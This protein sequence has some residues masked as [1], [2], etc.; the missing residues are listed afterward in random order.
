MSPLTIFNEPEE[1]FQGL[2]MEGLVHIRPHHQD[3]G[4]QEV[5][6]GVSG[7]TVGQRIPFGSAFEE[8]VSQVR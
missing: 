3:Q 2:H 8:D 5:V 1:D 7:S 6:Y 4:S